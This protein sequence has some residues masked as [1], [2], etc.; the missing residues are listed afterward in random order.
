MHFIIYVKQAVLA[1]LV[2]GLSNRRVELLSLSL[3]RTG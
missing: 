3:L 2:E 1:P